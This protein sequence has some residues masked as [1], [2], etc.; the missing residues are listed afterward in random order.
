[1]KTERRLSDLNSELTRTP[2]TDFSHLDRLVARVV[3][4]LLI[5]SAGVTSIPL[6]RA[7][8]HV[9]A[10]LCL[11]SMAAYPTGKPAPCGARPIIS[12]SSSVLSTNRQRKKRRDGVQMKR[13]YTPVAGAL[14]WGGEL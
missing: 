12:S 2:G 9:A 6:P 1:M 10:T 3:E 7:P 5:G 13:L 11:A 8:R 14:D 4:L